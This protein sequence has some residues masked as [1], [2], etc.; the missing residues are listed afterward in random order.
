MWMLSEQHRQR[1]RMRSQHEEETE[2]YN[3]GFEYKHLF[4]ARKIEYRKAQTIKP[5]ENWK[6]ANNSI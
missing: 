3:A 4:P 1:L 5:L 6:T 2:E